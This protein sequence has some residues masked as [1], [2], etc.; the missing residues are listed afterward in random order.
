MAAG[1]AFLELEIE[2][3][4]ARHNLE[5]LQRLADHFGADSVT[6]QNQN[7]VRHLYLRSPSSRY[8]ESDRFRADSLQASR[9]RGRAKNSD[10]FRASAAGTIFPYSTPLPGSASSALCPTP[11][12]LSPNA[13]AAASPHLTGLPRVVTA[14]NGRYAANPGQ[15]QLK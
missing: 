5:H 8:V 11:I 9:V 4:V 12:A 2:R 15:T 3:G 1:D 13:V 10:K 6:L 14:R 7:L